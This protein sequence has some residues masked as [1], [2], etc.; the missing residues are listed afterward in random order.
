MSTIILARHGRPACDYRTPIPGR[1]FAEWRKAED[2]APLD[3]SSRPSPELV[4][5]VRGAACVVT[6]PLRRS[7]ESARLLAPAV[8]PVTDRL[9][10]EAALP[11][12]FPS[13]LRL[14]PSAWR[15]LARAAWFCGWSDGLESFSAALKRAAQAAAMLMERSRTHPSIA[16]V[17]HGMMNT[18]IARALRA[19][20]W[21]GPRIPS[22]R[23]WS[24]GVYRL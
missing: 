23:H 8:K 5:L 14:S 15:V 19:H 11:C 20:G 22:P 24:Y 13:N 2:N 4:E 1:A 9:V 12:A 6:S 17:G 18:L 16:V 3:A 7:L 21:R 10:Q